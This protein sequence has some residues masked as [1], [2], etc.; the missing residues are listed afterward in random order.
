SSEGGGI[1]TSGAHP[2][3]PSSRP[4]RARLTAKPT[5]HGM[6][7]M[8]SAPM[9]VP[10]APTIPQS[11]AEHRQDR[12]DW[13]RGGAL[14]S[15]VTVPAIGRVLSSRRA[16]VCSHCESDFSR[17]YDASSRFH[18][19]RRFLSTLFPAHYLLVSF[20]CSP[21]RLIGVSRITKG[22][23]ART[24]RRAGG[25]ARGKHPGVQGPQLLPRRGAHCPGGGARDAVSHGR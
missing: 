16:T 21:R 8:R 4:A 1:S 12:D 20:N 7:I 19:K 9:G 22:E 23:R 25:R 13:A 3:A 24:R 17:S 11:T 6:S 14:T 2:A 5:R 18:A 15:A 10:S